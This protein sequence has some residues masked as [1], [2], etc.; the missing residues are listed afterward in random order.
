MQKLYYRADYTASATAVVKEIALN[1]PKE[2]KLD[3]LTFVG[4]RTEGF[5]EKYEHDLRRI[6]NKATSSGTALKY[7][8]DV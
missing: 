7:G 1:N 5:I 4:I 3:N 8:N 6:L 2:V